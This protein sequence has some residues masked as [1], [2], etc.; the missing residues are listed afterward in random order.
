MV[1]AID[2][3]R[4]SVANITPSI[5]KLFKLDPDLLKIREEYLEKLKSQ[6][7]ESLTPQSAEID[8][9]KT[10]INDKIENVNRVNI[11]NEEYVNRSFYVFGI[12]ICVT[13]GLLYFVS[14][15]NKKSKE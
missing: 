12:W 2:L 11:E 13:L 3:R 6:S 9:H 15:K 7:S 14:R 1:N 4:R 5:H 8:D 10:S